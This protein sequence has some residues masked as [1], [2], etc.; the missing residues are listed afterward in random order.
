MYG[1]ILP[2]MSVPVFRSDVSVVYNL[3]ARVLPSVLA[4]CSVDAV[5]T[6]PPY[7]L[8]LGTA[9]EVHRW[10]SSGI[11]FDPR[12]WASLLSLVK[13]GG[14]LLA[15]GSPRTWHRLVCALED[16]GWLIRDQIAWLYASGMP[17]GEWGD[18]AVDYALGL[19]DDREARDVPS[20][21]FERR[22][23]HDEPYEPQSHKA[24]A[25]MGVNPALKP[26]WEPILVV[27]RPRDGML[28]G[29]TLMT[30][31]TG[32]LNVKAAAIPAD[33]S[34]LTH[35][36][37]L[38]HLDSQ[39]ARAGQGDTF[40]H[41]STPRPHAPRLDGRYPS[42]VVVDEH[43]AAALRDAPPFCYCAKADYRERPVVEDMPVV[44]PLLRDGAWGAACARL[45]LDS[46]ADAYP[47]SLLDEP[48]RALCE[49]LP[50]RRIAHPTVKPLALMR[51][52]VR[53]ATPS[54][55]VVLDPFAG[56]G[57]TLEAAALEGLHS[58]GCELSPLYLP[59][60]TGRLDKPVNGTLF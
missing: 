26:A 10:D 11:A 40:K 41:T 39:G 14:F 53:L 30:Y 32:G 21:S 7:E 18:H 37:R 8:G 59:L 42:N 24:R 28:L 48:A 9:G 38:R 1:R 31:G 19:K 57:A 44:T 33:M 17:K 23:V 20:Q 43:V 27:Q 47:A 3:D 4:P 54:G 55:G 51:W 5:V 25:F 50:A 52:L 29:D 49:P 60:I 46:G 58:I 13:P 6:D 22:R 15:F 12:F 16:A 35:R 36:Y 56:S 34:T 45:G 2:S